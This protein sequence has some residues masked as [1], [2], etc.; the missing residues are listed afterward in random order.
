MEDI[1]KVADSLKVPVALNTLVLIQEL[2]PSLKSS[3]DQNVFSLL[4]VSLRRAVDAND[5]IKEEAKKALIQISI[6]L[7]EGKVLE[8]VISKWVSDDFMVMISLGLVLEKLGP[9]IGRNFGLY[10]CKCFAII[11]LMSQ[12]ITSKILEMRRLGKKVFFKFLS[13]DADKSEI[14]LQIQSL[15]NDYTR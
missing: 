5:L 15:E 10:K 3:L 8:F 4:D 12:M 11:K 7:H 13:S 9:R 2:C 6:Y 14:Q 1:A